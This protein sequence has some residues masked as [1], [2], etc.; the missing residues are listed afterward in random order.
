MP[1]STTPDISRTAPRPDLPSDLIPDI[2]APPQ[3]ASIPPT[4]KRTWNNGLPILTL[5]FTLASHPSTISLRHFHPSDAASIAKHSNDPSLAIDMRDR[6]PSPYTPADARAW[7]ELNL[8][9]GG[10]SWQHAGPG[11][12]EGKERTWRGE[13]VPVNFLICV[14]GGGEGGGADERRGGGGG[15]VGGEEDG[16]DGEGER[17]VGEAIGGIG[18]DF[19]TDVARRTAEIGYW[20]GAAYR[21]RG[22]MTAVVRAFVQ[23][24]FDTFE[25]IGRVEAGV[26]GWNGGSQAVLRKAGFVREGV[27]RAAC[28]KAGR[29]VD[30]VIFAVVREGVRGDGGR[31]D[32]FE[33]VI[34]VG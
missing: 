33:P 21:G 5:P 2:A 16:E 11:I 15:G 1:T 3:P 10:P 6:F 23:W 13:R 7:I 32:G 26:F 27:H 31:P 9:R 17:V 12:G 4:S 14:V 34:K 24:A 19:G 20:L 28:W 25:Q 18:L 8:D 22:I 30:M 29:F